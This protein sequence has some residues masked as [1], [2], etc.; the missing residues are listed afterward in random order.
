MI[1]LLVL[2][3]LS[4]TAQIISSNNEIDMAAEIKTVDVR[5]IAQYRGCYHLP[6]ILQLIKY[7]LN[8]VIIL[9]SG[10]LLGNHWIEESNNTFCHDREAKICNAFFLKMLHDGLLQRAEQLRILKI[11]SLWGKP[12][13]QHMAQPNICGGYYNDVLCAATMEKYDNL[14]RDKVGAVIGSL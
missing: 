5:A 2:V 13:S 8:A 7:M 12:I 4:S 11:Y 3:H 9:W 6:L 1:L 14:I 10:P